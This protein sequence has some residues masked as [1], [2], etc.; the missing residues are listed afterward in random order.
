M[1]LMDLILLQYLPQEGVPI[2]PLGDSWA[3]QPTSQLWA[4]T[5]E[6]AGHP[7]RAWQPG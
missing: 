5:A 2:H 7:A 4:N 1:D 3:G 6:H